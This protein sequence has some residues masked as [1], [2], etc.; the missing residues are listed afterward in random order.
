MYL[1]SMMQACLEDCEKQITDLEQ[2]LSTLPEGS[3]QICRSGSYY[4]WRIQQNGHRRYLRKSE[5]AQAHKLALK[6]YYEARLSDLQVEAKACREYLAASGSA[7]KEEKLLE[8]MPEFRVMLGVIFRTE[9]ERVREWEQE[10]YEKSARFPEALNFSTFKE[11][12]KV[13]SKLEA[14]FAGLLTELDLPYKY[15]KLL[16]IGTTTIAVDFT[17]LDKRTFQ[18]IP[19]E[20]FGMMDNEDYRQTYQQKMI[21]YV[22]GGYIPGVNFLTFYESSRTPLNPAQTK[23]A[24]EDFFFRYPPVIL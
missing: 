13:R 15:E 20:L 22:K 14:I 1:N 4:S 19:V 7:R 16:T 12:E 3:L 11:G 23:K 2:K 5:S 8:S 9:E 17:V 21:T 6:R 18:E 10:E 24:L